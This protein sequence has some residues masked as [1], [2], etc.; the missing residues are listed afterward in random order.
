MLA[1][2]RAAL[3]RAG[4]AR[5]NGQQL[6]DST[7]LEHLIDYEHW[8]A[9]AT[10]RSL[11]ASSTPAVA[12]SRFAHLAGTHALW[13]ARVAGIPAPIA[14]WPE[15]SVIAALGVIRDSAAAWRAYIA[16]PERLDRRVEYVNSKGESWSNTVREILTQVFLHSAYH[17]GQIAS[18]LR[19]AGL[20][21]PYTDYIQ[22]VRA[23]ELPRG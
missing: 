12:L 13:L 4:A 16:Q 20:E 8:A 2:S 15:L 14:V 19:A 5:D 3:G 23:R 1:R 6:M 9:A 7:T 11:S 18:D 10:A 17:R 21:P 22:A